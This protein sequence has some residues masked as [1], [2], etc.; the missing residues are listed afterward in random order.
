MTNDVRKYSKFAR[1]G[2][3]LGYEFDGIEAHQTG[4]RLHL[5]TS[6]SPLYPPGGK[7][8]DTSN[9][10]P[11]YD[12]LL[13]MFCV[14][15]SPSGGNNDAIRGGLMHLLHHAYLVFEEGEECEDKDID[16]IHLIFSKMHLAM[17]AKK[18]PPYDRSLSWTRMMKNDVRKRKK[19]CL[20]AWKRTSLSSSTRRPH[21]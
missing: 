10:L 2:H 19:L 13:C 4:N 5:D 21:T 7:L 14:N 16:V 15:I 20:R 1:F 18:I 3:L 8:G 11:L 12:V 9:L 6:K 17:I